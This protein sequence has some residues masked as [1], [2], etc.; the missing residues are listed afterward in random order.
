MEVIN[1]KSIASVE[2]V[3][4][5]ASIDEIE[6]YE[7]ALSYLLETLSSEEIEQRLGASREEVEGM[8]DDLRHALSVIQPSAPEPISA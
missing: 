4:V 7:S 3:E 2:L 1:K 5:R 8:C 6:A